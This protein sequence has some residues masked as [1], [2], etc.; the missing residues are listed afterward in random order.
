MGRGMEGR[1]EEVKVCVC[2]GGNWR[3]ERGGWGA[4]GRRSGGGGALDGAG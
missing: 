2:G 1:G 4:V 3:G